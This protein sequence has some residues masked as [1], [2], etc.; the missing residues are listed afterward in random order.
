M[1]LINVIF[2]TLA[3]LV[4]GI[5]AAVAVSWACW[6]LFKLVR[7]PEW[8]PCVVFVAVVALMWDRGATSFLQ[9][10]ALFSGLFAVG[11]WWEGS[12]WRTRHPRRLPHG[13]AGPVS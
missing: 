12:A 2:Q 11:C 6:S 8:G 13:Q 7:H 1:Y 9:T 3:T 5:L 4:G 10:V